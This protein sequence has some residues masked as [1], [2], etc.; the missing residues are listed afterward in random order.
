[1]PTVPAI[2]AKI[3]RYKITNG[4]VIHKYATSK[5]PS[6][7]LPKEALAIVSA[8]KTT[9]V[10]ASV[11]LH[12]SRFQRNAAIRANMLKID[13]GNLAAFPIS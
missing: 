12:S 6:K 9:K 5:C 13:A 7:S 8:Q 10:E 11:D 1:V 2:N 4:N 3:R